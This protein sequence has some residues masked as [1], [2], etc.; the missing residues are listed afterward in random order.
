MFGSLQVKYYTEAHKLYTELSDSVEGS[1]DSDST[2]YKQKIQQKLAS[3]RALS[4]T[5]DD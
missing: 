3:I 4:I 1:P 5:S 2:D